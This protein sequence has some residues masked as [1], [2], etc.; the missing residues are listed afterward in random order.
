MVNDS[1]CTR[2]LDKFESVFTIEGARDP[3]LPNFVQRIH[4]HPLFNHLQPFSDY[5]G[6]LLIYAVDTC[7]SSMAEY[8]KYVDAHVNVPTGPDSV[9]REQ[10]LLELDDGDVVLARNVDAETPDFDVPQI[11]VP[12]KP[13][14]REDLDKLIKLRQSMIGP[15]EDLKKYGTTA[16][17]RDGRSSQVRGGRCYQIGLSYQRWRLLVNPSADGK[18]C[19][20][21]DP[22]LMM[23]RMVLD[24]LIAIAI[25]SMKLYLPEMYN[26]LKR[27][28]ELR[29]LPVVGPEDNF[30]F[31]N[32]QINWASAVAH[33]DESNLSSAEQMGQS[34]GAH[35]D[36]CDFVGGVSHITGYP[37]VPANYEAG[38]FHWLEVG[39][40]IRFRVD[41]PVAAFF[42]GLRRHGGTAP[43]LLLARQ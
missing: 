10:G 19:Q 36:T 9:C 42:S 30:A 5:F 6:R 17:E 8:N 33:N 21:Q 35:R 4:D 13:F 16:F 15:D 23:R 34:G 22:A 40:Y 39:A 20:D 38:R 29:N 14:T 32:V 24:D 26:T 2:P 1:P 37:R 31:S 18:F 3:R 12:K 25:R 28:S 11:V 43:V 7:P 27:N 41:R